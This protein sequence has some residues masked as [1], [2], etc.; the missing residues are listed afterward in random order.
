MEEKLDKLIKVL[1]KNAMPVWASVILALVPIAISVVVLV[2]TCMH[3]KQNKKVQMHNDFL[4]IYEGFCSAQ[5]A[6]D[7]VGNNVV[8][9]FY[10]PSEALS[11]LNNYIID[12]NGLINSYDKAVLLLPQSA[13]KFKEILNNIL[14][15]HRS[16]IREMKIYFDSSEYAT[17]ID[18]AWNTIN[19]T[20]GIKKRDYKSLIT[21]RKAYNDFLKLCNA[22]TLL[23]INDHKKQIGKLFTYDNFDKYFEKYVRI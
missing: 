17:N 2:V 14:N 9:T 15:E 22:G 7:R 12:F 19:S 11:W 23:D 18:D 13:D 4:K 1:E 6:L 5:N 8:D 16:I 20:F 3:H 10:N 21:N